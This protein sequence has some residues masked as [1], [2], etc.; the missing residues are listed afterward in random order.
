MR[1]F[2][3]VVFLLC[4]APVGSVQAAE[5][6]LA[7][8]GMIRVEAAGRVIEGMPLAWD[9]EAVHLLGRDGQLSSFDPTKATDF[10]R[11]AARFQPYSV[12]ELRA[13]LLRELG[14]GYDVSG[15][16]HYLIAHPRGRRDQWA[17]RFED[18][19]RAFVYYFSVR[20]FRIEEPPFPLIGVV[21]R[22]RK[23]F[24]RLAAARGIKATSDAVG[25]YDLKTNRILVF[26]AATSDSGD[27]WRRNAAT[28]VHEATHQ[29]AFNTG[30]HNRYCPPPLWVAEGLATMFEATGVHD[31][32]GH[33]SQADRVNRVR[34]REY[35]AMLGDKHDGR[36]P[37]ELTASDRFFAKSP[38]AAYAK[39]WAMTFYLMETQ[40]DRFARYLE[41]TASHPPLTNYPPE[42]RLNDFTSV[43]GDNWRL[44]DAQLGRF[45]DGLK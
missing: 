17:G 41:L 45:V 31:A 38:V 2:I 27:D 21:C 10:R 44:F 37:A 42:R 7:T 13:R 3:T 18:L 19:Y 1:A 39:A 26:D 35:R 23:E 15:T 22:D 40:P 12:S 36:L 14:D 32:R 8:T 5:S 24:E 28:V 20:G 6:R 16:T 9:A 43:F 4:A 34:L 11:T 33:G 30:I 25:L 29:M